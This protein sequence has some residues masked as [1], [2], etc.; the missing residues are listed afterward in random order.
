MG[1][2]GRTCQ[3]R[4]GRCGCGGALTIARITVNVRRTKL[5]KVR[6]P[7]KAWA[8]A[9]LSRPT[10]R[11]GQ[12]PASIRKITTGSFYRPDLARVRIQPRAP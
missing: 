12:V 4:A 7:A 6:S 5:S 9:V 3:G 2:E 8:N 10:P 11:A 1:D